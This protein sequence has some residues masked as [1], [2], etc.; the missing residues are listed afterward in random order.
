MMHDEGFSLGVLK[1]LSPESFQW[2]QSWVFQSFSDAITQG[3]PPD[4]VIAR[5]R[6]RDLPRE[7]ASSVMRE[8]DAIGSSVSRDC[9]GLK[10]LVRD[11]AK[12][13]AFSI[14]FRDS[15][16]LYMSGHAEKAY[17]VM[18]QKMEEIRSI[19]FDNV[20]RSW[21]ADDFESR[22]ARREMATIETDRIPTGIAPY[23]ALTSGGIKGGQ[24]FSMMAYSKGGKTQW[25]RHCGGIAARMRRRV[26]HIQLEGSLE[27]T[28]DAY[29]AWFSSEMVSNIRQGII[30]ADKLAVVRAAYAQL[31]GTVVIRC[32][33]DWDVT[34]LD[35]EAEL[36]D[37]ASG[38]GFRP[39]LIILDYLDLLRARDRSLSS[40]TEIQTQTAKD[41][42]KLALRSGA[43]IHTA[44]QV[45]RPRD[46]WENKVHIIRGS[47]IADAYAKIRPLDLSGSINRT[48]NEA[49][50]GLARLFV[51]HYRHNQAASVIPVRT[52][53]GCSKFLYDPS[54]RLDELTK[55][56][57]SQKKSSPKTSPKAV[58]TNNW[59]DD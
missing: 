16:E 23:D 22:Q 43:A 7:Q 11:Y 45:S 39:D 46:G 44:M 1:F 52:D 26:L 42:K 53:F 32:L 59:W 10:E 27:E 36:R 37:L 20:E 15:R 56:A 3:R 55:S 6:A 19:G 48:E 41:V 13:S 51:E 8:L 5:E 29:D 50:G 57:V 17:D 18:T 40:E 25:L 2:P 49:K 14:A 24:V 31:R 33:N 4:L 54:L 9:D 35:I 38:R 47:K 30:D 58:T 34:V 12:R 21:L 28:E